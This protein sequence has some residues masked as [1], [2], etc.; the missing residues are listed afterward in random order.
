MSDTK[1]SVGPLVNSQQ[2]AQGQQILLQAELWMEALYGTKPPAGQVDTPYIGTF[3]QMSEDG[4]TYAYFF[5]GFQNNPNMARCLFFQ[6][7][8]DGSA[9]LP[10][11]TQGQ[12]YLIVYVPGVPFNTLVSCVPY[13][14]TT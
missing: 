8:P 4:S 13:N 10:Q 1:A 11:L 9:P 12:S 6:A 5:N 7:K 14:P 3:V 2:V